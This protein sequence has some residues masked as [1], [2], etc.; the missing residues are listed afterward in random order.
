MST[1][2]V[3]GVARRVANELLVW[4]IMSSISLGISAS[5]IGDAARGIVLSHLQAQHVLA[6]AILT[7]FGIVWLLLSITLL[8]S[9]WVIERKHGFFLALKLRGAM[10]NTAS[11]VDFVKDTISLYRGYR[12]L[13]ITIG[14]LTLAV[15]VAMTVYPIYSY[16]GGIMEV[17][18]FIFRLFIGLL[19]LSYATLSLYLEET[20]MARR[21]AKVRSFEKE[22]SKLLQ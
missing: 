7:S 8:H 4:F 15:G 22:L 10:L 2:D 1:G 20:F 21:L 9:I 13:I 6:Y 11:V 19:I 5:M 16:V 12:W 17:G 3:V 18:E 14:L